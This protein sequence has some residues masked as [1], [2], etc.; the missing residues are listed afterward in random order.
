MLSYSMEAYP[1]PISALSLQ[2]TVMF[3]RCSQCVKVLETGTRVSIKLLNVESPPSIV[4]RVGICESHV[5]NLKSNFSAIK[6][7][8]LFGF[9]LLC[10]LLGMLRFLKNGHNMA[11]STEKLTLKWEGHFK[12]ADNVVC[13]TYKQ[14]PPLTIRAA[15]LESKARSRRS[16]RPEST[17][18]GVGDGAG[19][20]DR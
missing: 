1:C 18:S 20:A 10:F 14:L 19:V 5:V 15:E 7:P 13:I 11:I 2:C 9:A 17:G 3:K 12:I 6:E 4:K 16:S 8:Q